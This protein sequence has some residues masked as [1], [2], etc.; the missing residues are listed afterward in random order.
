[1]TNSKGHP[2]VHLLPALPKLSTLAIVTVT[3]TPARYAAQV[4]PPPLELSVKRTA[5]HVLRAHTHTVA[6]MSRDGR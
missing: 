1:M 2:L 5:G 6:K 4:T 3:L